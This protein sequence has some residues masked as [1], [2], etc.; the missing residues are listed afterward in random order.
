MARSVRKFNQTREL[1]FSPLKRLRSHRYFPTAVVGLFL[2]SAGCIHI[3]QRVT[4]IEMAKEVSTLRAANRLLVD[5]VKKIQSDIS[6]LS[7]AT[8]IEKFAVDSLGMTSVSADRLYTLVRKSEQ[9]IPTDE[10][11][12]MISSIRR[13]A[14]YLPVMTEANA[15]SRDVKKIKF[16]TLDGR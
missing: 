14:D 16:K 6:S 11:D 4:V 8:R 12:A 15:N 13:V 7:S 1:Q 10:F 5:D 3:W 9:S 2:I